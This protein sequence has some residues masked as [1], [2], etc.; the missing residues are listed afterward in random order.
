MAK[1]LDKTQERYLATLAS[2]KQWESRLRRAFKK[3]D[4]LQTTR[5][6]YERADPNLIKLQFIGIPIKP[7]PTA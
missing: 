6:R 2:L 4:E 7:K 1:K 3:W 5:K